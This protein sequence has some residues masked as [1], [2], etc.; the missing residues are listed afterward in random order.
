MSENNLTRDEARTRASLLSDLSYD[1]ALDLTTGEETFGCT[2]TIRFRCREPGASTFVDLVAPEVTSAALNGRPLRAGAFDGNRIHVDELDADNVLTVRARCA[3][4][5]TG[6][7]LHR[8]VDPVDGSVYLFTHFEPFDAHRV[9]PCFD[10]P[11]LKAVFALAVRAPAG[12]LVVANTPA[13]KQ[14]VEGEAGD[15]TF[16]PTFLLPTYI[17]AVVAGPYHVERS[18]HRG[19]DLGVY[20]R[21]SLAEHLDAGEIVE[22]TAQGLDFYERV[23]DHKYPFEKYD[24][25]FVP[26][27]NAGA[28]ENAAC[29][30][31]LEAYVFRSKVTDAERERRAETILHELAHMWFGDLVTMRWWD[32]LWLNESFATYASILAQAE[33]TRFRGSW[34]TFANAWKTWAYRQDQLPTTHPIAADMVDTDAVHVN[35]DG[36][37]Y[38][39][40]ASVLR[41]LVAWVGDEAFL[42]GC[43]DYF[44]RHEWANTELAD[45]LAALE[46]TS[47]RDLDDWSARWLETAGV[48]TVQASF[49][50]AAGSGQTPCFSSFAVVQTAP[51]GHD[52]LRPHRI[53]IG[54]YD[55]DGEQL[56]RHQRVE[57]DVDGERTVVPELDGRQVPD[58]VLVNDDDLAYTKVRFDERS[59]A[60][61][62]AHLGRIVDPLARSLCWAATW[63]MLRDAELSARRYLDVVLG[64]IA[65]ESEISVITSLLTQAA[66]AVLVLG[67]PPHREQGRLRLAGAAWHELGAAP[68]RSDHQLAWARAFVAAAR[69]EAH[70]NHACGLL[71]GAV[72]VDGLTIDTEFRWHVIESLAAAGALDVATIDAEAER[73][74]TDAGLR[75]AAAARAARPDPA[76][77]A[78]AWDAI[79]DPATAL[80][81]LRA[82]VRGFQQPDQEDLLTPYVDPYFDA[83]GPMW[84]ERG[85]E[86]ALTFAG[87]MYPAAVA[88]PE[89]VARTDAELTSGIDVPPIRR[90]LLEGK[91]QVE[92]VLRTRAAD[93]G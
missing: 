32:D 60:T 55:R 67:A 15:W 47:G 72:T 39:K 3:Y 49:D 45:F 35:F 89:V 5:H 84:R 17:T 53:A 6:V 77:K 14:P 23:F 19:I 13:V 57:I 79:K 66:S 2:T 88:T 75:H 82:H 50:T 93:Q 10:Q 11:D 1:I 58:L 85:Q 61:V 30:T 70:L 76:A 27:F 34:T 74:P 62:T 7:G 28:M 54:L 87:T 42:R 51:P 8:F 44:R 4:E 21:Q 86:V 56:T 68:P 12:W 26:E 52:V 37:T 38:A 41:Q 36:I 33:A 25:V 59:L 65:T 91:D 18:S 73:D 43:A 20:C 71:D 24:Q 69:D 46:E 83:L 63:D 48:N 31:F 90:L 92:R 40:G 64:N 78:A 16:A 80:A 29:V 9:Y 81:M 22:V